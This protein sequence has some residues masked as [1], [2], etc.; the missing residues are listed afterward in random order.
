MTVVDAPE[1]E[2]S[3]SRIALHFPEGRELM[4]VTENSPLHAWEAGQRVVFRNSEWAVLART[5]NEGDDSITFK[6]GLAG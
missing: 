1:S 6:L 4:W 2:N 3:Q 5:E